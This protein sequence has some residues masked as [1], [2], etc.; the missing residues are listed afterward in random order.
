MNQLPFPSAE[1]L[2]M[3]RAIVL[4]AVAEAAGTG[5]YRAS[6]R[7]FRVHAWRIVLP[8]CGLFVPVRVETRYGRVVLERSNVDVAW[9]WQ[10]CVAGFRL[11]GRGTNSVSDGLLV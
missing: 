1:E 6:F 11:M 4:I 7:G 3:L 10:P 8:L 5:E 9:D 2:R